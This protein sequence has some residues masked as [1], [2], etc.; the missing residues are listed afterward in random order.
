MALVRE[1]FERVFSYEIYGDFTFEIR[2]YITDVDSSLA[3]HLLLMV[4]VGLLGR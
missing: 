1:I 3:W 2:C 4:E